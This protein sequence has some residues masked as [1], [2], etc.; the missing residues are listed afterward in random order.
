MEIASPSQRGER[1]SSAPFPEC[2][3]LGIRPRA[4]VGAPSSVHFCLPVIE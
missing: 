2:A 4:L 1:L 3:A